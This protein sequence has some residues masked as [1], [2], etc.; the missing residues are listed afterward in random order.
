MSS[1]F[2]RRVSDRTPTPSRKKR[3]IEAMNDGDMDEEQ[4]ISRSV[5]RPKGFAHTGIPK[6]QLE[7]MCYQFSVVAEERWRDAHESF[8]DWDD[9]EAID[10]AVKALDGQVKSHFLNSARCKNRA[11][12]YKRYSL[13]TARNPLN[14]VTDISRSPLKLGPPTAPFCV[15]LERVIF[16]RDAH[17]I[18]HPPDDLNV[19]YSD[20][21][22]HLQ[23][24]RWAEEEVQWE[25]APDPVFYPPN[26]EVENAWSSIDLEELTTLDDIIVVDCNGYGDW[27]QDNDFTIGSLVCAD[28]EKEQ[29][30]AKKIGVQEVV[31]FMGICLPVS[32]STNYHTAE[33][34]G[35]VTSDVHEDDAHEDD[36]H[37]EMEPLPNPYQM[38]ESAWTMG[39]ETIDEFEFN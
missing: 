30:T 12:T 36:A 8:M 29:Q 20:F 31:G 39:M 5:K 3:D 22:S 33:V 2:S 34:A 27:R 15:S 13:P 24:P 23:T 32:E 6:S 28:T 4:L 19:T 21:L 9:D 37:E 38:E 25:E 26:Y 17:V 16:K 10:S 14:I 11:E 35:E 7:K 18:T 1:P